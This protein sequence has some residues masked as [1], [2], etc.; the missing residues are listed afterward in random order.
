[1]PTWQKIFLRSAGVGAGIVLALALAIAIFSCIGSLPHSEKKWNTTVLKS[2]FKQLSAFTGDRLEVKFSF[3]VENTSDAD[4][5]L[6]ADKT[7]L[8]IAYPENKGFY[9]VN[10]SQTDSSPADPYLVDAAIDP[11]II[12]AKQRVLVTIRLFYDYNATFPK[13][14]K[15]N[16][17]KM[18]TYLK[19][20]MESVDGFT[21]FDKTARY[22]IN[23]TDD[24]SPNGWHTFN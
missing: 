13:A 4:Y 3:F 10:S 8:Y 17:E 19:K 2:Q 12:P 1:M 11:A 18:G 5:T 21:I 7:N 16:V 24:N 15:D 23:L 20:R 14:E 9:Q 6:P 22:Q